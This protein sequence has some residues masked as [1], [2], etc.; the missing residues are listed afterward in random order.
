M[1]RLLLRSN[2][3]SNRSTSAEIG[4]LLIQNLPCRFKAP[5]IDRILALDCGIF[6]KLTGYLAA[7][8][9]RICQSIGLP[10]GSDEPLESAFIIAR[11]EFGKLYVLWSFR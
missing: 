11:C 3:C 8:S 4:H 6:P 7:E 9:T 10:D 5:N 2:L 1:F